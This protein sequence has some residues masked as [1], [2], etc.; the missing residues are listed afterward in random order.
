MSPYTTLTG[1]LQSLGATLTQLGVM[2]AVMLLVCVCIG[3]AI[4]ADA[5]KE[6]RR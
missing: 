4:V 6:K 2:A 3:C 5:D 1:H